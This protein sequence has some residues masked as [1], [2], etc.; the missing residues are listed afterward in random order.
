MQAAMIAE[1]PLPLEDVRWDAF[2]AGFAHELSRRYRLD[3]PGWAL[4][5]DRYLDHVWPI[6]DQSGIGAYLTA[7]S[8]AP[9]LLEHGLLMEDYNLVSAQQLIEGA[10]SV[11]TWKT[12]AWKEERIR[13]GKPSPQAALDAFEQIARLFEDIGVYAGIHLTGNAAF[14]LAQSV[15]LDLSDVSDAAVDA[16]SDAGHAAVRAAVADLAAD[17]SWPDDWPSRLP[18]P[19]LDQGNP[20]ASSSL[21]YHPHL[22]VRASS[23]A[24]LAGLLL[25]SGRRQDARTLARLLPQMP[26][27]RTAEDLVAA[28]RRFAPGSKVPEETLM[29]AAEASLES[30]SSS[31]V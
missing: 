11:I 13:P 24:H 7:I 9:W 5:P 25:M 3:P 16:L 21:F 14:E 28:A 6:F 2:I 1:E 30:A 27:V 18:A 26:Y 29:A 15:H 23:P 12:P 19:G 31:A 4:K 22:I 17:R 20:A 10:G 8:P